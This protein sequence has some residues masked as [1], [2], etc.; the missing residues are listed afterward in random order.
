MIYLCSSYTKT[1]I[2][3]CC[4]YAPLLKMM[5]M[6]IQWFY[7]SPNLPESSLSFFR[8]RTPTEQH[9]P[10][11]ASCHRKATEEAFIHSKDLTDLHWPSKEPPYVS[12]PITC[13]QTLSL[14]ACLKPHAQTHGLQLHSIQMTSQTHNLHSL[15]WSICSGLVFHSGSRERLYLRLVN[16][17]FYLLM[18]FRFI[19]EECP[20]Q[21]IANGSRCHKRRP[22]VNSIWPLYNCFIAST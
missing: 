3:P 5:Q 14:N 19:T 21:S 20:L 17:D 2:I 12:S 9:D 22:Y 4:P 11:P 1:S 7:I 8:E 16:G 6:V 13:T 10:A 15:I 18:F